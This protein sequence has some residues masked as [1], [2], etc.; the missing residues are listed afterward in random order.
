MVSYTQSAVLPIKYMP[1]HLKNKKYLSHGGLYPPIC[2]NSS[3]YNFEGL[4]ISL[5][6]NSIK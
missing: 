1:F 4:K 3:I 2:L 6:F 5:M